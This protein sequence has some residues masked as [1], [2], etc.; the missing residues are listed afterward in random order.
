[1]QDLQLRPKPDQGILYKYPFQPKEQNV[2]VACHHKLQPSIILNDHHKQQQQQQQQ[3]W[4][5]LM[6]DPP[7]T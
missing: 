3:P 5:P 2:K 6:T 4:Y 7:F 1:M